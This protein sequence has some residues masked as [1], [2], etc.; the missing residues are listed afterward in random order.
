MRP[1]RLHSWRVAAR[2]AL[3]SLRRDL[4]LRLLQLDRA[5]HD[6]LEVRAPEGGIELR[7]QFVE[8]CLDLRELGVEVLRQR[9][10]DLAHL[11]RGTELAAGDA[12]ERGDLVVQLDRVV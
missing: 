6:D 9:R 8:R 2:G 3:Q 1:E 5:G 7:E 4:R 11:P 12:G 10:E